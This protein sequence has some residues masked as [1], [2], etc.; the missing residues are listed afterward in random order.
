MIQRPAP[1]L[2]VPEN[3]AIVKRALDLALAAREERLNLARRPAN[4]PEEQRA[5]ARAAG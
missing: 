1:V 4:M 2:F 3:R 5:V